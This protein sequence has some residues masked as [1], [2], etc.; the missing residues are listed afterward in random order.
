MVVLEQSDFLHG[1]CA[2]WWLSGKESAC[3]TGD[4][5]LIPGLGRSPGDVIQFLMM[6]IEYE[7][8]SIISL[9][10]ELTLLVSYC[11]KQL[12]KSSRNQAFGID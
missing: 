8:F 7:F 1:S 3:N 2:T 4:L 10:R 11:Q 9:E 5:D 6:E 12:K